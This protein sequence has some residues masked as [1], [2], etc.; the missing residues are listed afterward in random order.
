M[1]FL[2]GATIGTVLLFLIGKFLPALMDFPHQIL[3]LLLLLFISGVLIMARSVAT[4]QVFITIDGRGIE[5]EW[6]K[7]WLGFQK[8]AEFHTWLEILEWNFRGGHLGSHAWSFDEFS[9]KIIN[10]KRRRF[11][12]A[13]GAV[14]KLDF[15]LFFT[16]FK[17]KVAEINLKNNQIEQIKEGRVLEETQA[18][19]FLMVPIWLLVAAGGTWYFFRQ[20]NHGI[21]EWYA[22]WFFCLI[23]WPI[24]IWLSY[25]TIRSAFAKNEDSR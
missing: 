6:S 23:A 3:E 7:T 8:P 22:P 1:V 15:D 2:L 14:N 10:K 18:F 13:M 25:M 5:I 19:A 21:E 24:V 16:T 20:A 9:I 17:E 11:Y 12:L 4:Q